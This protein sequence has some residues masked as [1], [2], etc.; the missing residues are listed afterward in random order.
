MDSDAGSGQ[1]DPSIGVDQVDS[2]FFEF[3]GEP[4]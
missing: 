4:I 2:F 1:I 3:A